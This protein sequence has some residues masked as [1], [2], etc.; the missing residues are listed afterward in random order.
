MLIFELD[1]RDHLSY[2]HLLEVEYYMYFIQMKVTLKPPPVF[3][4][5]RRISV[6]LRL[7]A[8]RPSGLLVSILKS[9]FL[10]KELLW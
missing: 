2:Q 5:N 10:L 4:M 3:S 6:R 7:Q 9:C 1:P 8:T